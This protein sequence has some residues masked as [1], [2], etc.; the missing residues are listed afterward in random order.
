[1]YIAEIIHI[2]YLYISNIHT[3]TLVFYNGDYLWYI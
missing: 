3:E 2:D 1:M